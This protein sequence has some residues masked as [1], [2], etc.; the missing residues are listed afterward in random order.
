M[1]S[2]NHNLAYRF[3]FALILISQAVS[4]QD[5]F[6]EFE[7][8]RV[9]DDR[10]ERFTVTN[11]NDLSYPDNPDI[12]YRTADYDPFLLEYG[13]L[14]NSSD[15]WRKDLCF[16]TASGKTLQ[17]LK[18]DLRE[19]IPTI[20]D[21]IKSD[22][23]LSYISLINQEWNR[24]QVKFIEKE[25][26][27]DLEDIKR[28]DVARNC[29]N[30]YLW[31]V[32]LYKEENGKVLPYSHGWF[33]FPP[34]LYAKLFETKNGQK[35]SDYQEGM[36]NWREPKSK[37]IALKKLRSIQQVFDITFKD[38]SDEMYPK[39]GAR[40]KKYKEIISPESFATM[41]DL[42]TDAS[43]FATFSPPGFYNRSDPRST[44]LG[45]IHHLKEVKLARVETES[46]QNKVLHE[47]TFNFQHDKSR[48]LTSLIIGGLD[49][50][51]IP[52]LSAA[53]AN[54]GW[55]NSM[56]IGNHSFYESYSEHLS[57]KTK[58]SPYYAIL[59]DDD[60][61]WLDSHKIGI[62]GPVLHFTDEDRTTLHV[63]L[64]SF[65]R[66][67]LVGHYEIRIDGK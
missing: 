62:D 16:H 10:I 57:Y 64:L 17:I 47:L 53:Q 33:K 54:E 23:Y 52:V 24:N 55:K 9:H 37:K 27:T 21:R 67:A 4:A 1:D 50:S 5:A 15:L 49:L 41:R 36:E 2:H 8:L 66:H 22:N 45:R 20:P 18:L 43:K 60:D 12:G 31:E 28:V 26:N 39:K 6:T 40:A 32:I 61:H 19:F 42:Q 35:W 34:K 29:L 25:F 63:W 56:G 30:A 11:L 44:E 7:Y 58:E 65:E 13:E 3:L 14:R 51:Q 46:S 59:T 48:I 38:L